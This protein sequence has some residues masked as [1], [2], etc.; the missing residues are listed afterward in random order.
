MRDTDPSHMIDR[1]PDM[2]SKV[3]E[4]KCKSYINYFLPHKGEISESMEGTDSY[5]FRFW[6]AYEYLLIFGGSIFGE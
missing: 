5:A 2:N 1:S 3:E 4:F 6:I